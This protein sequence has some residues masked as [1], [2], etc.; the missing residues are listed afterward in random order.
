MHLDADLCSNCK[1]RP[2]GLDLLCGFDD[3]CSVCDDALWSSNPQ[4]RKQQL[5]RQDSD[6]WPCLLSVGYARPYPPGT[7]VSVVR[8]AERAAHANTSESDDAND[9]WADIPPS[10]P[11]TWPRLTSVGYAR[12]YPAGARVSVDREEERAAHAFPSA[13][14]T[15]SP[16][17][18]DPNSSDSYLWDVQDILAERT[19]AGSLEFLVTFKPEWV[20]GSMIIRDCPAMMRF[21]AK[22]KMVCSSASGAFRVKL[23]VEP[24]TKIVQ[25][26][27]EDHARGVRAARRRFSESAATAEHLA[28]AVSD[29]LRDRKRLNTGK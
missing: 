3:W 14:K 17:A 10:D 6:T 15:T 18:S 24:G 7:C 28:A 27:A 20:P 11:G 5:G 23:P 21:N 8:V 22:V 4:S 19:G 29:E 25:D 2:V 13:T 9:D 12:P 16:T 26:F 1:Q